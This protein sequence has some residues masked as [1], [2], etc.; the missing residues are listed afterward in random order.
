M[1]HHVIDPRE[2]RNELRHLRRQAGMHGF[3]ILKDWGGN[4]SLFDA[5]IEPQRGLLGLTHVSLA[6]IGK[7]VLAPLPPHK[8]RCK[9]PITPPMAHPLPP[10]PTPD[11]AGLPATL[12]RSANG[13]SQSN[14][15]G[16]S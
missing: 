12:S 5:R 2:N 8:P 6:E 3:R 9:R 7:A 16:A 10:A 14:G 11:V 15:G 4:F 1:T 13:T